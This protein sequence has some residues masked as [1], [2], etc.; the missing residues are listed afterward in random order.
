MGPIKQLDEA[1]YTALQVEDPEAYVDE[2]C[3]R[4]SGVHRRV[5]QVLVTAP[6]GRQP[7]HPNAGPPP[8]APHGLDIGRRS[9]SSVNGPISCRVRLVRGM[10]VLLTAS[11]RRDKDTVRRRRPRSLKTN[12]TINK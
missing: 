4:N 12:I 10:G 11:R 5:E 1:S 7:R 9:P 8:G 2:A 6:A 3:G